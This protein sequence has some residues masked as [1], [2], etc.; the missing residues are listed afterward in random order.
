MNWLTLLNQNGWG[1]QSFNFICGFAYKNYLFDDIKCIKRIILD[2]STVS[3]GIDQSRCWK[4]KTDNVLELTQVSLIK[5]KIIWRH[6]LYEKVIQGRPL[7][8][9]QSQGRK[10]KCTSG[11]IAWIKSLQCIIFKKSHRQLQSDEKTYGSLV[12]TGRF[13]V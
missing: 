11:K 6:I 1:Y 2:L 9:A 13:C 12:R 5:K 4:L 8:S 3:L 10:G 7:C